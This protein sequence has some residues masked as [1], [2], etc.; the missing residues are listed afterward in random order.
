VVLFPVTHLFCALIRPVAVVL[1]RATGWMISSAGGSV[2][3]DGAPEVTEEE[4]ES[5][6][7]LGTAQGALPND[8]KELLA[9]VIEFSETL[10]KEIMV[11]R[12]DVVAF[13]VNEGREEVLRVVK[14]R[15]FSRYPVYD[16][17]LDTVL[18]IVTVK[19]L[20]ETVAHP[21]P[22]GFSLA[23]MAKGHKTLIVPETKKI[24]DLLK[25]FQR[26][27]VQM[28][29]AVDEFGGTAGIVTMEDVI[30]EIVG[31]IYDE[32]E[33]SEAGVRQVEEGRFLVQG[34][35][36]IEEL[37][38]TFHVDLPEQDN[39]ETVGGLVMTQAGKVPMPGETVEFA[40]LL[41]EVRE[42]T[43]TRVLALLVSRA[44]PEAGG[45]E[46]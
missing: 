5:M 32:H 12:T 10:T 15:H 35:T 45:E 39:Y 21:A 11:A 18:G 19:D 27:H 24:G 29:V 20:L 22:D 44:G 16:G 38:E 4:I 3:G 17:D 2:G 13:D 46:A 40:G 42:R 34:R 9:S 14:D 37:A 6:I 43:R 25:D 31:E 8:K 41:F 23:A 1:Q 26:E 7:R 30:E 36:A 33:R 28:A